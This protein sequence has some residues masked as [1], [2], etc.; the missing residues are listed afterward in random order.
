MEGALLHNPTLQADQ[1]LFQQG[2]RYRLPRNVF[3]S[4]V[5]AW[6]DARSGLSGSRWDVWKAHV[7][8][9][10]EGLTWDEFMAGAL[11]HNPALEADQRLFQPEKSYLLPKRIEIRWTRP[12]TGFAG[13]RWQCWEAHVK[14]T[15][16]GLTS[17]TFIEHAL[18]VN[19]HLATDGRLFQ[20]EK[21]Y[22]LPE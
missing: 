6:T 17:T 7:E 18:L 21:R 15:V 10:V 3:G 20:A 9:R 19:P 12:L 4:S 8:G 11:E 22:W 1:R 13:T 2:K 14:G 16:E 5:L